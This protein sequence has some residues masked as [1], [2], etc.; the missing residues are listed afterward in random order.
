MA[1]SRKH[2]R[3]SFLKYGLAAAESRSGERWE[4]LR[5]AVVGVQNAPH[6]AIKTAAM[7]ACLDAWLTSKKDGKT[8][9]SLLTLFS[10]M[11]ALGLSVVERLS[12]IS[13]LDLTLKGGR[14]SGNQISDTGATALADALKLNS[15]LFRVDLDNNQISDTGKTALGARIS[16]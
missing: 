14:L 3:P 7:S 15:T 4:L 12:P 10:M 9:L 6:G 5:E 1:S 13:K 16:C 8:M 2:T 11:P